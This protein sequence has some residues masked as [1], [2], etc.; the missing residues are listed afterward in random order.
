MDLKVIEADIKKDIE[1]VKDANSLQLFKAKFIGKKGAVTELFSSMKDI[2]DAGEKKEKGRAINE[3]KKL[4]E[5]LCEEKEKELL[6]EKRKE[7]FKDIDITLP[8]YRIE[9]GVRHPLSAVM[10]E[11]RDIFMNMGFSVEEGPEIET[12]YNNFTALNFPDDHPALDMHDTFY[13]D[14]KHL[15]RTHTSPVQV[16]AMKKLKPPL[17]IL[18]PGRVYRRDNIDATHSSVFHQV[19]GFMVDENIRF[20][21]LKGILDL[22]AKKIFGQDLKTRFRPSFF[23]FTEPSA[24]V[25]VQCVHCRGKGCSSCGKTGW[26]EILGCGMIHPN[27]LEEVNIDAEKFAGFAFGMGVER[28]AMLKYGIDDMRMFFENDL[29]FLKQFG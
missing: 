24:E 8:G 2:R 21:D 4:V 20:S 3:L 9:K 26:L 25:D 28:I 11:I 5:S 14:D 18:A 19:E 13:M 27:V 15:L 6:E 23:P 1:T 29:R 7:A 16:R 22:F 17:K 10:F 12:E